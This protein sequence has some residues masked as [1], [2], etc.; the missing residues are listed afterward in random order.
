M[1]FKI[2]LDFIK[3][4]TLLDNKKKF[5]QMKVKSIHLENIGCFSEL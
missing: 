1:Q 2:N 5:Y 4:I 3:H